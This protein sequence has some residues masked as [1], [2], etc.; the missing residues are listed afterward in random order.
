MTLDAAPFG[1]AVADFNGDG[2]LDLVYVPND[3]SQEVHVLY[4][5]GGTERFG[6]PNNFAAGGDA[7]KVAVGDVNG[8]GKPDLVFSLDSF[9]Q[10]SGRLSVL[11]N[12]GTGKFGAPNVLSVQGDASQIV[13]ADLNNDNKLDIVAPLF[14]FSADGRVAIFLG[15]GSGGF[16]Q[17]ANSPISTLSRN[18]A[19]LVVGDFNEDG[20]HD[21]AL[22]GSVSGVDVF[23][24]DGAGGFGPVVNTAFT[25]NFPFM[26]G[27][28][29]NEDG[30]LD[31]LLDRQMILGT[32]TGGFSAP[33]VIDQPEMITLAM[34]GD[35]N[36]D[37]HLDV[38]MAG[39]VGLTIMLGDGA[40]NLAR[41]KSYTSGITAFAPVNSFAALGDFNEDGKNDLAAVQPLGIAIL[42]GDGTG[43]F[44]DALN[45]QTSLLG[46]RDLVAA[47]FNNDGKKDFA[48]I[49]PGFAPSQGVSRV[50]VALGDGNGSFTRKS[51]SI[52]G[53]AT[54]LSGITTADFNND[55]KFDLA[56]TQSQNGTVTILL[57]DGTGGFPTD[58]FSA[59]SI[60][61]GAQPS[62]IKAGDF[63]NDNKSDLVVIT[64]GSN[65]F[66]VLVGN[67]SGG[68]TN[69]ASS[70]L[71][72]TSSFVDDVDIG[73]FD[74]D[75]KS[76]L[77][78]VRSG[79]SVV[80]V[81]RGDGTGLFFSFA[82]AP[83]QGIPVSVVVRD[84]SGDGKPDIAVSNT[85]FESP[86][87]QSSVTVFINNGGAGFNPGT[88]YPTDA[89]GVL[90]IGDFNSDNKPDL[91]VSSGALF[92]GSNMEGLDV[93]TNKGDGSFNPRLSTLAG[94]ASDQLAVADFNND[95]KDDVLIT[96]TNGSVGLLLNNFT[97]SQPC[98]SINDVSITEGDTGTTNATFTVTLSAA[99]AQ[100]VRVN[101]FASSAFFFTIGAGATKGV[102][103]ENV[104][105]TLTFL[106][107]ETTQTLSIPVKGDISDEP[108][109]F[110]FVTLS[111]PINAAISDG[112]GVATIVDNDAPAVIT[113]NDVS[114]AEGTQ[115]QSTAI[116]TVSLSAPSEKPV[117]LQFAL[118]A[119]TATPNVDYP[120]FS[121]TVDFTFGGGVSRTIT[122]PIAQ[123]NMFEPDETF[124][125]NLNNA[126]N[127]TIG[128]GQGQGTITNDDPQPTVGIAATAF[129]VEG[130]AGT[131]G[132]TTFEVRL[133][134]PSHQTITVAFATADGTA[135][136]G[137]D[138]VATS[139]TL[140][141]NPGEIT[142]SVSV[143]VTGD[144]VD[145][146][147][148]TFVVN[149]S[150][151]TNTT[152]G[153]AQGVGTI[154]DDDGPTLSINS[155][156][157]T[158]GQSGLTDAVFTVTL[159]APSTQ[160]VFVNWGTA[161]G[162]AISNLDYQRV[163][164]NSRTLFIPAGT[165]S[166]NLTVRVFG[167]LFV[168]P[169][170][171]FFVNLGFPSNATI[172]NGQGTGTILND[173]SSGKLQFSS[174]MFSAT[175][176][177]GSV[178]IT[179]TRVDGATDSVTVDFAT[180]NGTATAGSDYTTTSGTLT[181]NHGQTSQTFSIPIV[182]DNVFEPDETVNITLINATG[183]A[184]LGTPATATLTITAPPLLLLLDESGPGSHQVAALDS[185]WLLRDPFP[186]IS[187]L[188]LL[189][190]G[191]D[192]N[193]RVTVFVTN[194]QL[195]PGDVA[196]SVIVNLFDTNG[197]S[198]DVPAEDMR[199]VPFS[200]FMQI[201]FRLPDNL[202]PGV[203]VV[204][205][206]GPHNQESNS[207]TIRIAN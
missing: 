11:L 56:V 147:N 27:G 61:V 205:L 85:L 121:G 103:Y 87:R 144:N 60:F 71:Q 75:G 6:P 110:F 170:E 15:N 18:V 19:A 177:V 58:G 12:D 191:T 102:D 129:R 99:S 197:Q 59:P 132:N 62:S 79:A 200:N 183:G 25:N 39:F 41:G 140:T 184:T 17:T 97:T 84:F 108:D 109:Q 192:R 119:G 42:D 179:V 180:S 201:S 47:D 193:T 118:E 112:R 194:L 54:Q 96:Q 21:L 107:G 137:V 158:E 134:N 43:E 117:S 31:L 186:V 157:V 155:V 83:V 80:D 68:F 28:D 206:K 171:Q 73:D 165:T 51:V 24:G 49:G 104:P 173:D 9:G 88:T 176:D 182:N 35:V 89:A 101:Y 143:E 92:I 113:I 152:I 76:D 133:S 162:T 202:R 136:A 69:V 48:I 145:E 86:L 64:P 1:I 106:P 168:E 151:P 44:N 81:R 37:N 148:E 196:S 142:K 67:G 70:T 120:N 63:N 167:D 135:T 181:F 8:D 172:A 163:F 36:H 131:S 20:K 66:A 5:R 14:A 139:G 174:Q 166:A 189:H 34:T 53:F 187:T 38:V 204:K 32:G 3:I 30:H 175:E 125:V 77:A 50:E 4:G 93:L 65:T 198:H 114:V 150:N 116:F 127:A 22:P 94:P 169:N 164:P 160:D 52:F 141:F 188:G 126:V 185:L 95:G 45:Y 153:A 57:N 195:A 207:G 161:D 55:G 100:T 74:G 146:T 124:F 78:I 2:H 26:T 90:G 82:V 40:G 130:A 13:L 128:D 123:D 178:V 122:I 149:L 7:R 23:P 115:V 10:A 33:I 156:S 46:M 105:G 91:I 98:L 203:C 16:S 72:G 154:Q 111:T 138:Y 190:P 159:S 199:A 29:F